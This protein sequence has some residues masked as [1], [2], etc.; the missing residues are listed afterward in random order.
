MDIFFLNM[1]KLLF[2]PI[3]S[4]G[5]ALSLLSDVVTLVGLLLAVVLFLKA[6]LVPLV[7]VF[8]LVSLSVMF[9]ST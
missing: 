3:R 9:I 2:T 4:I 8:S 7:G 1:S 5:T 6:A